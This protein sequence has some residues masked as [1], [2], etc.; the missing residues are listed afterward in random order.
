MD[1]L[2]GPPPDAGTDLQIDMRR[3]LDESVAAD[4]ARSRSSIDALRN[5]HAEDA[6]VVGLL[7]NLADLAVEVAITVTDG[8]VRRGR[9]TTVTLGGA[10]VTTPTS[11]TILRSSAIVSIRVIDGLHL[12]GDGHAI[13][14]MS[15]PT[16][17]A[18]IIEPGDDVAISVPNAVVCGRM[19]SISRAIIRLDIADGSVA[20]VA[21]DAV[22][23]V[24]VRV[25]GAIRHDS[26]NISMSERF[27]RI[28]RP[29]R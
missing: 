28:T 7:A 26:T 2:L 27:K 13:S 9:I 25:P 1:E 8:S 24:S 5:R 17:V 14:S 4:S 3:L 19:R 12:D 15:W 23:E 6:S 22:T 18:S 29:N 10:T 16:F 20:Y 11:V 21:L